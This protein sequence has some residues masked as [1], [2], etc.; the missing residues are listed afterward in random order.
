MDSIHRQGVT[1]Q[2]TMTRLQDSF[3]Y[4]PALF[5][6]VSITS[7]GGNSSPERPD[8]L[9]EN[10][11][12]LKN[13]GQ[14]GALI[15]ED[16]N[17]EPVWD[18]CASADANTCRGEGV[19][20][21]VVD[22]GIQV[23]HPD[24]NANI[25]VAASYNYFTGGV[26]PSPYYTNSA[27]GTAVAG[28]V[29]ARDFNSIG[30]RG[31]APRTTLAG[32]NLLESAQS[33]TNEADAM[34]R[35]RVDVD[36]SSNSWG[37]PD[38]FGEPSPASLLW[39]TAIETGLSE[40]RNGRGTIYVWA[41]GNGQGIDNSNYDG[42]ANY[43]G[44]MAVA[45]VD[46]RGR[47]TSYSEPG[48]NLLVSAPAGGSCGRGELAITTTDLLGN[49]GQNPT[50]GISDYAD[51]NYTKCMSGTSAATPMV[52]GV[53]ALMLQANPNLGW[54]DVRQI[55]AESARKNDPTDPDWTI[56]QAGLNINHK[57]GF[58]V[59]D[60]DAAVRLAKAWTNI[61]GVQVSYASPE[62][63]PA[64]KN[65][66]DNTGAWKE[67]VILISASPVSTI[68][69]VEIKFTA[70]HPYSGDLEIILTSPS[71]TESVLAEE[72]VCY[73]P[74]ADLVAVSCVPYSGW[75]FG[76]VRHLGETQ[77]NGNWTLTVRDL[78]TDDEGTFESWQI[79][80]YGH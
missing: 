56:N 70:D 73:D 42:M 64:I 24:L 21:V 6:L 61:S 14:S 75:V 79:T 76:T 7:C 13:T 38:Y 49:R 22:D 30:G 1:R 36:V 78:A 46:E 43:R 39:Q 35:N 23:A 34:T 66:P 44:V 67:D 28:I 63:S 25:L 33:D 5:L 31:V 10:Q 54:R 62:H 45:A 9:Y 32:Y 4:I 77:I 55:L 47:Q 69:F 29:A 26:D 51:Q 53:V 15:D 20:V 8:H 58:G 48:A 41:G 65:I 68:E 2:F 18:S 17:V 72:H 71:G 80:I 11:W 59:V 3:Y 60:A 50:S 27:H 16:L 74:L 57:Y 19:R 52:S 12:H 40:G 37:A